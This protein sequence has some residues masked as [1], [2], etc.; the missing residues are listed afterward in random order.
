MN[1]NPTQHQ[2][3]T[4]FGTGFLA[5]SHS[6]QLHPHLLLGEPF[7]YDFA[8]MLERLRSALGIRHPGAR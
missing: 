7:E 3:Q 6:D 1:I 5:E 2:F 8:S 4:P